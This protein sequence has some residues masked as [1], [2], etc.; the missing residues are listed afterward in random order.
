MVLADQPLYIP[1]L[2]HYQ[3]GLCDWEKSTRYWVELER[4]K[5]NNL[6]LNEMEQAKCMHIYRVKDEKE[7]FTR[8]R[9]KNNFAQTSEKN[10]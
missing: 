1:T 7:T 4:K 10:P 3:A 8:K 6:E 2:R 5:L 9:L